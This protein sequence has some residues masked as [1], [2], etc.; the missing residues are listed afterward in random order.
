MKS[1]FLKKWSVAVKLRLSQKMSTY[2]DFRL[3]LSAL[4]KRSISI[5]APRHQL[6]EKLVLSTLQ[7]IIKKEAIYKW[8]ATIGTVSANSKSQDKVCS[9]QNTG[10]KAICS[11][12]LLSL[13]RLKSWILSLSTSNQ[14]KVCLRGTKARA[15][16][17]RASRWNRGKPRSGASDSKSRQRLCTVSPICKLWTTSRTKSPSTQRT[18]KSRAAKA[19]HSVKARRSRREIHQ[20]QH[21]SP[22]QSS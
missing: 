10:K 13:H 8:Y 20:R 17:P 9:R 5:Q 2:S 11:H 16:L 22:L 3:R 15:F 4:R 7:S 6:S 14:S 21:H 18:S 19:L 1:R 12:L